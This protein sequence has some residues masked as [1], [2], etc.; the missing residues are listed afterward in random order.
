MRGF[1]RFCIHHPVFTWCG[2][3]VFVLLGFS[4]YTTLGVTLYPDVEFPFILVQTRYEG[5]S[6]SEIEQLVSRPLE[7]SLA[8]LEGLKTISSY[9]QDG[10]SLLAV[11]MRAGTNPDLALVDVNN[12]I[13]AKLDSLPDDVDD[14]VSMKFDINAEPF[15]IAS[16]FSE[17]PERETKKYIEDRIK[18]LVGRVE[19]VGQVEITGGKDREIQII[20]DP[21]ALNDYNV[22]YQQ[23]TAVIA[24]NNVTNPSGYITQR[25]DEITLRLVGEFNQVDQLENII[26][27]TASG[28][29]IPLSLLG[30]V[31]DGEQDVRSIARANGASVVQLKISPRANAD[32]VNAGKQAKKELNKAVSNLPW[33]KIAYTYDDTHYI[34]TSVKNVIRD[35]AIGVLLTALVIYLFLGRLSATFIVAVSMPVAFMGTFIPMQGH[36]YTLNLMSTLG[37]ALSMGTLV[38]NSILIIQNIYRYRDMG[39]AP[40][41][42]AEEGTVEISTSV[43]AGVLTNLGVFLPVA[44][45]SGIAGQF[46]EPYAVTIL[47]A[48]LLSLWVTMSVTPCMAAR[49]KSSGEISRVSKFLTGWWNWLYEGFRELFMFLLNKVLRYPVISLVFFI[50][51]LLGSFKLG[52]LIGSQFVPV[53]DDGTIT[54]DLTLSNSASIEETERLTLQVESFIRSMP[55]QH[56]MRDVVS[57][58]GASMQRNVINQ[59]TISIYLKEDPERPKTQEIADKL[60]PFLAGLQGVEVAVSDTRKGFNDPIE[61]RIKGQDMNVLYSIAQE[62]RAKGRYLTGVRDLRIQTEMG[63]PELQIEPIRWRLSPLG[64]NISDLSDIVKGYLIGR[65]SGKF[66]QDGFEY[67]IKARLGREKAGDIYTVEE[68]PIMTRFGLVPLKEMA[69]VHWHDAPTEIRR[70]ERERVVVVTG[71]V[72]YITAGEGIEKMREMI[73]SLSLPEGYTVTFGGEAE[74]MAEDFAELFRAMAIAVLITYIIVAAIME[75]WAYAWMI[76]MTVPMAVIGIVPAML[77]SGTS[78][79]IFAL[80]GMIMLIGM[81]VNNAIVVVDYAETLRKEGRAPSDAIAEASEVRFKS[82]V[83]AVATSVVSLIPLAISSGRGAEMRAPIAVVAI[84]GLIAG[85]LLALL[86]IPPAYKVYWTVRQRFSRAPSL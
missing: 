59:S 21:A 11:E 85:G 84:G 79:S 3:I 40:F 19:G 38:M 61:V 68:L 9:S 36:G 56:Y 39:Y 51:L 8:D 62:I 10:V 45:M 44:L 4:S 86:A 81:V 78:I 20:L 63:K 42:A 65:N 67:D 72:R 23:I 33:L 43:L 41:E 1:V 55:E 12:K 30:K 35:T 70:I 48:T 7:D 74:D 34:E 6:P 82:L 28:A 75:S 32:V 18:P 16:F 64:I 15:L 26:I 69:E 22:T 14:P 25:K 80:I 54:I 5:A 47:Y 37:L 27:P 73:S 77:I 17:L 66:R 13:K 60:R 24:A 2:V 71:N 31:I 46:L 83:M 57:T 53:T 29:P 58:V 76:L 52:G 50:L 49:V